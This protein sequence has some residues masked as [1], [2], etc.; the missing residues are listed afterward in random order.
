MAGGPYQ[1]S[2]LRL[3]HAGTGLLVL[4]C[5]LSG[6]IVYSR[7]DGRWG[8]LPFTPAGN[9]IDLHGQAGFLLL[10][11]GLA[12]AA[13]ALSLGRPTLKRSTN[14]IA[15][16][17]LVLAVATGKLMNEVW[18]REGDLPGDWPGQVRR[19]LK[20]EDEGRVD[21]IATVSVAEWLAMSRQRR[22]P[23]VS[24]S[25]ISRTTSMAGSRNL[26]SST[27]AASTTKRSSAWR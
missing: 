2:L 5:W 26:P 16:V 10:P 8:R 4:G 9:W 20:R 19:Y 15:L 11:L 1:P 3:L 25:R 12:F 27:G 13:Y 21:S 14:A 24:P 23:G 6:L 7:Y 22:W 17:A 18:L